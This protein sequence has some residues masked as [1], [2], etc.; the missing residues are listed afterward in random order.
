[1]ANC[2]GSLKSAGRRGVRDME[3]NTAVG[4]QVQKINCQPFYFFEKTKIV[5]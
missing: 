3:A 5:F 1:M 4:K 2:T